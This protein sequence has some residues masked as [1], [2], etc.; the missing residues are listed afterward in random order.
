MLSQYRFVVNIKHALWV[1][2]H[3]KHKQ[4]CII[5]SVLP[6]INAMPTLI[7]TDNLVLK[8]TRF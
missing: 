6:I 4:T 3:C 1:L 2:Q 5:Q 7:F 8:F